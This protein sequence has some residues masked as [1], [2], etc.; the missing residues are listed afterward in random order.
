MHFT[1]LI[2]EFSLEKGNLKELKL[3]KDAAQYKSTESKEVLPKDSKYFSKLRDFNLQL[4][5]I[6][7]RES[8]N[9]DNLICQAINTV[10]ET[11]KVL[12][13]L[14]KRLR[15]WYAL[16]NPEFSVANNE[17]YAELVARKSKQQLLK[18]T[19]VKV[20]M[21]K[22]L[23]KKDLDAMMNLAKKIDSL[24]QLKNET[25]DYLEDIMKIYCPNLTEVAGVTVGAKL[26]EHTGSLRKLVMF[27][28]STIQ[29][30]GA[31]KAL[32]RHLKTGARPPRHGL[33]LQHIFVSSAPQKERGRRARALADK[34]SMAV[35]LDFF[36]GEFLGKKLKKQL[37]EKFK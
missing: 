15:E 31:E 34:L 5:K 16:Y 14:V 18:E 11:D 6:K 32:F 36:K 2:G 20:S 1:H 17:K 24:V 28:A 19:N 9:E 12:N 7:I 26:I 3:Y 23:P 22:D 29:I 13:T 30:L 10:A 27:P 21:G 35:K 8:V 4:T 25:L 33:I 37:E